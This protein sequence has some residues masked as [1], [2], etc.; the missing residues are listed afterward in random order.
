[1]SGTDRLQSSVSSYITAVA[2]ND[3]IIFT[4]YK[5]S[6]TD[7]GGDL[8]DDNKRLLLDSVSVL[9]K[10]SAIV[11]YGWRLKMRHHYHT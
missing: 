3:P 8:I 7:T 11:W 2:S 10:W 4:W 1:M 5:W 9:G 6:G